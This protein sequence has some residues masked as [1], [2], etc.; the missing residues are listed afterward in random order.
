M[1]QLYLIDPYL[2]YDDFKGT[3]KGWDTKTQRDFDFFYEKARRRLS[4]YDFNSSVTFIR[5]KSCDA[6]AK[7][8]DDLDFVYIDGNHNYDYVKRDLELYYPKLNAGGV[9]GGD[10]FESIFPGV[11]KAVIEFTEK[12]GLKIYG[13]RSDQSY[14]WWVVKE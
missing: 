1:K 14:E 6:A 4:V 13:A 3:N 5:Q 7:I 12:H 10:N 11:A 8:P 9:V 2:E